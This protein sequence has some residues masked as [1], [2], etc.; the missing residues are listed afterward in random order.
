MY[1][2]ASIFPL[3][4]FLSTLEG[5][6]RVTCPVQTYALLRALALATVRGQIR[7]LECLAISAERPST[8]PKLIQAIPPGA[9][10]GTLAT[11]TL[12][13]STVPPVARYERRI[14]ESDVKPELPKLYIPKTEPSRR[15]VAVIAF[16]FRVSISIPSVTFEAEAPA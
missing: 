12:R 11:E 15:K 4:G 10:S 3:T 16:V 13:L 14:M 6:G 8:V 2:G 9:P 1:A 7:R 5:K